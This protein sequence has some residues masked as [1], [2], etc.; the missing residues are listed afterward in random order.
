M[1]NT[2][3]A[4]SKVLKGAVGSKEMSPTM[5]LSQRA[6]G[7]VLD[8]D[9]EV[10]VPCTEQQNPKWRQSALQYFFSKL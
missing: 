4:P 7:L 2:F 3:S 8:T 10:N 5:S 9:V 1:L 6:Q